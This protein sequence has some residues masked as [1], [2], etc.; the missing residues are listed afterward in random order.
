LTPARR[1][2]PDRADEP[3]LFDPPRN[4]GAVAHANRMAVLV[5]AEAYFREFAAAAEQ[6]V[7][8]I[9]ILGWDFDSR[10]PLCQPPRAGLP[11][12]LGEFLNA[13]VRRRRSLRIYILNWDYPLLFATDRETRPLYGLNWTPA[14]HVRLRY[15]NTQPVGASHHQK[16]VVVDDA[17]AFAGGLDL[18]SRRWDTCDHA[19][20]DE[21]RQV[22]GK[23]YP[24]FHDVMMAVDDEAARAL[25]RIARERW[26][27]ATGETI[28]GVIPPYLD[29]ERWPADV[30]PRFE[31]VH[32]AISRTLPATSV[33]EE[34]R[35][36][37]ALYVDM[38]ARA[39]RSIYIENQ[40]FTSD[41]VGTALAERLA[42]P[43]APEIVLVTRLLSHGWLEEKTMTVLRT[44]LVDKVRGA[45]RG[46]R[47]EA[48]YPHVPELADGTC[49]DVHSKLMI[50][51]DEWLRVG[52][53]N[54][55]NRSMG[56]DTECD[57]T[58]EAGGRDEVAR[59]IASVRDELLAEHLGVGPDVVRARIAAEG[60]LHGAIRAL[61]CDGRSLR[62]LETTTQPADLALDL[63][64]V[65]DPER[66]VSLDQMVS[67]FDPELGTHRRPAWPW[68]VLFGIV[69][70]LLAAVWRY[71]PVADWLTPAR[72]QAAA[73]AARGTWWL[74]VALVAAY[75]FGGFLMFPRPLV[76]LFAVMA[77]GPLL[78]AT[79]AIVGI[80]AATLVAYGAGRLLPR[81]AIRRLAG[82][83]LN[84]LSKTLHRG[85]L[86]AVVA[87]SI[88][89]TAPFVVVGMVAGAVHVRLWHY[90]L[91][92]LVGHL[93]GVVTATVFGDQLMRAL[94]DPSTVSYLL[95][96]VVLVLVVVGMALVRRG[97]RSPR[98]APGA[99]GART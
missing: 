33:T 42:A 71:T 28:P 38:I 98:G 50:V 44:R 21:R 69:A 11:G 76:T 95:V 17:I 64:T 82:D 83:R 75:A 6:A 68:I 91:G 24:P 34:T 85:G 13:L 40:Y 90:V 60:S 63:A 92:S 77:F 66:P 80:V 56:L 14:R 45:D 12:H 57:L 15:D 70:L 72:I 58:L 27:N 78:G 65:A 97:F 36:I 8:T 3:T 61:R 4:C 87:V 86:P 94:D 31:D 37:E 62:V 10:T 30:E 67:D 9:F 84:T 47:F 20:H 54:L 79:Y 73:R 1:T 55:S 39:Q 48:Y 5:D 46:G 99:A 2:E 22:D 89:P 43:D 23:P 32:V 96:A 29:S 59:G 74:P 93:P 16:I 7:R 88:V 35:E 41:R 52:S 53:A 26:R 25:G 18:A 19:A 81:D 49:V 51:D